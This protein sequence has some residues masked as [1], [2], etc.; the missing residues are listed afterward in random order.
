M[1]PVRFAIL[2]FGNIA[3]THMTALRAL[4]I[5]KKTPVIPVLDTLVTRRPDVHAAQAEAI[6]FRRVTASTQEA[7]ADEAVDIFDVCTPNAN[8][9]EDVTEAIQGGKSIYCEKPVTESYDKSRELVHR[10]N[11][12]GSVALE[13]L[14]FTYRYH[15][16]VMRIKKWLEEGII[17]D[18]LQCKV[19]YRRSGYLNPDRPITWRLQSGMS[20]GGAISDLGVHVLDL[21]RHW[22][23]ELVDVRGKTNAYVKQRP[24]ETGALINI[25]VD[26][27]AMMHYTTTSDV[28]GIVEVSRI[29]LGSDAYDI[30]IVGTRGSITCDLE[31]QLVPHVH[32]LKGGIPVLPVPEALSLL[33][34]DKTTMGI[35][36]DTHFAAL[37]HFLWRFADEDRWPGLAPS[38]ADGVEV[39]YWIDRVLQENKGWTS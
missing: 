15:P 9:Y 35:A 13:Q 33:P 1:K 36:V 2:G 31:R 30:Q 6:G 24:D 3:K 32:L 19:S 27:W 11:N 4:P 12:S 22:F 16:A 25:D 5:I 23:G 37:N 18:V 38:M 26:D 10:M 21:I 17:G 20:G 7:A 34:D 28:S 29:A 14:A 39:E 8:H